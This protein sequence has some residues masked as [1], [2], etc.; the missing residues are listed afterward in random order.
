LSSRRISSILNYWGEWNEGFIK[1]SI[2]EG[3]I[4]LIK[5]PRGEEQAAGK[6]SDDAGNQKLSVYSLEAASERKIIITDLSIEK[7]NENK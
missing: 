3:K 2:D 4:E 6:V 1:H 7:K 5:N